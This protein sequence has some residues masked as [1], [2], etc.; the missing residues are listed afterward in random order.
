MSAIIKFCSSYKK[1][2]KVD[3]R[4]EGFNE[5]QWAWATLRLRTGLVKR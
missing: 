5:F 4:N 3:R 1:V 2:E